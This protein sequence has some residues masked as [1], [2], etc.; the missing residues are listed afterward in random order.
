M[1]ALDQQFV[2]VANVTPNSRDAVAL[3]DRR[4]RFI[5]LTIGVLSEALLR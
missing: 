3:V 2:K 4:A 1:V 5:A